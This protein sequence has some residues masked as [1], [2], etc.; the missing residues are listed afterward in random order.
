MLYSKEVIKYYKKVPEA[1]V[2]WPDDESDV[3]TLSAGSY[4][5]GEYV[6]FQFKLNK[7]QQ[8]IDCRYQVLGCG[9][10]IALVSWF[11]EAVHKKHINQLSKINISTI[12]QVFDLPQTKRHCALTLLSLIEKI[13][14]SC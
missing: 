3:I 6:I 11:V 12:N 7:K 5:A 2:L 10:M 13:E 8:I 1:M 4:S 14:K 9:Y